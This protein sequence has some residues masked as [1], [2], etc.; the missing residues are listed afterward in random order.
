M[1]GAGAAVDKLLNELG[2]VGASSPLGGQVT[3]LLLGGD[4]AGQQQPEETLGEGLLATGGLG[5]ELLDLGDLGMSKVSSRVLHFFLS[6]AI[7]YGTA[8]EANAL[9]RVEDGALHK[10]KSVSK[11]KKKKVGSDSSGCDPPPRRG[12]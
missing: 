3:N 8:T 2:D 9:L 6:S 1:E 10:Q 11:K 4:L 5:K 7:T 12:T